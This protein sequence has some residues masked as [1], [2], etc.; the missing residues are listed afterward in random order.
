MSDWLKTLLGVDEADIPEG[1]IT[2][3]EFANLPS[4]GTGL[5]ALLGVLALVAGV[6]WIYRREGSASRGVKL[7]LATL[8]SLMLIAAVMVVLEPILAID[9]IEE[10]DKSTILLID[11][12]LSLSAKDRYADPGRRAALS[13]A[14]GVDDPNRSPR[15]ELVNRALAASGLPGLL[16]KQNE[17]KVFTFSDGIAP[18][19]VLPRSDAGGE[20]P[21]IDPTSP[22]NKRAAHGTNIAGAIRQVVEE[23]GSDR[24]AAIVLVG[25]GR[26]NLGPPASD[27][28]LFLNNKDLKLHTVVVGEALDPRNL[29]AVALAGPDRVFKNDPV[30]LEAQVAGQGYASA[31]TV[32]ERRYTDG[33]DDWETIK[34]QT[35]A[36]E[37]KK[38]IT[39]RF[40]DRPPRV[41]AVEYRLRL[42][43]LPDESTHKDNEKSFVVR[44]IEEKVKVLFVAGAPAHEY[45]AIKNVLLRDSTITLACFLQ[46]ADPQFPQDGNDISLKKL[47]DT[48]KELF[49]F[50]VVLM[51]DPDGN[52]FP[53]DWTKLL[54]K[55][56][57]EHRGGLGF[58]C[59]NKHTLALLRD[60]RGEE[61]G[62]L[63]GI[64][65]VVL[66]LDRA[67]MPGSGIGY[68]GYFTSPWRMIPEAAA[69]TH[70]CTRFGS[71]PRRVRDL[72][73]DRLPPFY[74]F[75]PV[76]KAKPGATVLAVHED[77][78]EVVEPYGPRP[79][80]AVQRYG[81]GNVF[82]SAADESY[83]WRDVAEPIFERFWV[84]TVRFLLEGRSAGKRRRFRIYLDREV[85]GL[86]DA[87][88]ITA[89]VFTE[90][91]EPLD[92]GNV[93]VTVRHATS[94]SGD[95]DQEI[96]ELAATP[97]KQ[98]HF[99]GTFAPPELGDYELRPVGD[100]YKPDDPKAPDVPSASFMVVLPDREM[101]NVKSDRTLLRNLAARTRGLFTELPGIGNIG[102]AKLIP[103]A[104]ER[105]VTQGRPVPLWDT[106]TTILVILGLLCAEWILR[107]R[108]RMV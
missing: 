53:P 79:I 5:L 58:I 104:S 88:Q 86:G 16:A 87:V 91:Y 36:F 27:I 32:L 7:G 29:R 10:V 74:W 49:E 42:D 96:V 78:G 54:K 71:D 48:E 14:T 40:T 24:I 67:D 52:Q 34:S 50:D 105:I 60:S 97:G 8:R 93:E 21:L 61:E 100:Q 20:I 90:S 15:Y 51:H 80:L 18:L 75:F 44:V 17:V 45:Y 73:W 2:S 19:A 95:S 35:V 59:G 72:V 85:A 101:G 108:F 82:F 81:G 37:D 92:A 38:P 3:F 55:F 76:L 98:G 94:E 47:P 43:K 41:G 9:R 84:Q 33:S 103:P 57:A 39:L 30:A 46:S 26:S 31:E 4:G 23:V 107:K 68:G 12:S 1:A 70:P 6:F 102:D 99:S 63:T 64:L 106:W 11:D 89:Q 28:A 13:N 66:D 77:P 62:D 25:D 56:V 65:P 83:R 69:I 22:D